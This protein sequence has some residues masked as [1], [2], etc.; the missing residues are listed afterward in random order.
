MALATSGEGVVGYW[1][2]QAERKPAI[3]DK[4]DW[5]SFAR[6]G[7]AWVMAVLDSELARLVEIDIATPG[8]AV[9]KPTGGKGALATITRPGEACF[10]A[11][12]VHLR[13]YAD[14]R[15]DRMGEI[16]AQL[17]DLL[18]FFGALAYLG[19]VG[20]RW[21]LVLL[22]AFQAFVATVEHRV[23]HHFSCPRPVDY[24]RQ[25]HPVIQTPSH[26]T[27]PSGHATEAFALAVLFDALTAPQCDWEGAAHGIRNRP[28]AYRLASRIA[29]NRTV[30]GVHFPVDSAAGAVL[31]IALGEYVVAHL[32]GGGK[33]TALSA[34]CDAWDQDFNL[35]LLGRALDGAF[36]VATGDAVKVAGAARGSILHELWERARAEQNL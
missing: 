25:V 29:V 33:V 7:R 31:G 19:P 28:L 36:G 12:L 8:T 14:L 2:G 21:S 4:G 23:K 16:H 3:P 15:G 11:Q 6:L 35:P 10:L 18:P 1:D 20:T 24:A 22:S 26:S 5:D 17:G 13:T 27:L 34:D 30:A 32:S 9:V